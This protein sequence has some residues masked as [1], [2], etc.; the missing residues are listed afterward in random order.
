MVTRDPVSLSRRA[1]YHFLPWRTMGSLGI[2]R[3]FPVGARAPLLLWPSSL[4]E[5]TSIVEDEGSVDR[6]LSD[7]LPLT[8][9]SSCGHSRSGHNSFR[10]PLA[11]AQHG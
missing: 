1:R 4:W 6:C 11:S 8:S 3:S 9:A 10:M 2:L 5:S 7:I